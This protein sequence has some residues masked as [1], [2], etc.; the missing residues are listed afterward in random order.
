MAASIIGIPTT[1]V[2]DLFIRQRL[3]NQVQHDQADLFRLQMQL[4]TGRRFE[5]PSEAPVAALRVMSLQRLLERKAQVA[6]NLITNQS[7]LSNTDVTLSSV[8]NNMAEVR[9]T[10]LG[11][12]GTLATDEQRRAAA[13]Q[14]SQSLRSLLE[15]GNQ[16][17]RGR[18][19][20]AGTLTSARPFTSLPDGTVRYNGNE[21]HVYS[22]ADVN[23]LFATNLHGAE[24]FG[25]MSEPVRGNID[26]N[27]RLTLDTR[28][29][30]LRG[31]RG[32]SKGSIRISDGSNVSTID[33]S[34][35]ETIGDL[36]ALIKANP[37]SGRELFVEVTSD[38]I[39]IRLGG[40]E[41]NLSIH[42]VGGGTVAYE[43]GI[44][45]DIG[46]GLNPITGRDLDPVLRGTTSLDDVLGVRAWAVLHSPGADNDIRIVADQPGAK[47]ADGI[48]LNGLKVSLLNDP[49]IIAGNELVDYDPAAGTLVVRIQGGS[50]TAA[51]VAAAIN[52]RADIPYTASIDR[53]DDVEGGRGRVM[54]GISAVTAEGAGEAFDRRGLRIENQNETF[55]ADFFAART[56]EDLL[57]KLNGLGAGLLA[58]IN[59]SRT[60]I[61][62]R[63]RVSGCD[64]MIGENGGGTAE[65]LGLRTFNERTW[66]EDLNYGR[67]VH[68]ADG[69][70]FTI[71]IAD[72]SVLE[73]DVSGLA[74]IGDV[75]ERINDLAAAHVP[76]LSLEARLAEFGNGI[77]LV[78]TSSGPNTLT[79]ERTLLSSAAVDLGLVPPGQQ[80]S[81][82]PMVTG[83]PEATVASAGFKNNVVIRARTGGSEYNGVT[84]IFDDTIP[85]GD[86]A[87]DPD[88]K[89]L[90][91][92][93]Q[94]GRTAQ[95]LLDDLAGSPAADHFLGELD[96]ADGTGN[97]GTGDVAPTDPLDPPTAG[98]GSLTSHASALVA[99]AGFDNDLIFTARHLGGLYNGTQIHFVDVPGSGAAEVVAYTAGAELTIR[100]DST[101]SHTA[102][103]VMAAV[104]AHPAANDHWIV[105]RDPAD[106]S[107]NDG[108]EP[109]DA[110]AGVLLEGGMQT[111]DGRDTRP[112][113][114]ESLF[115][116]LLRLQQAL[117]VNDETGI[118]RALEMLDRKVVDLNFSRA[119]LGARQQGIEML[120]Y[121]ID[122][123]EV[124]LKNVLS[125]EY[126]ADLVEV[127]SNLSGRQAAF[128]AALR[129]MGMTMK[130]SLL[131]YL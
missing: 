126:D 29:D 93:I 79:V 47:T 88:A 18:Y 76:P 94:G 78:D 57:N 109:V 117:E 35:A 92:G 127:I 77:A 80:A 100:F 120:Q 129:S 54:A 23:L 62:L 122:V 87:Y 20:F 102:N 95:E 84:V 119:E 82:A 116:A 13:Q 17:F 113:E 85:P 43:L 81:T 51:N 104:A 7:Y 2:S 22:F 114:V 14:V 5:A 58:E 38:R 53:L 123:E 45:Q 6:S 75:I 31:G 112:L 131:N 128:E 105:G 103:D 52:A 19:L 39:R 91:F 37:P 28:I 106:E 55:D 21:G 86:P 115:T 34:S 15:T 67:G 3:L 30:D 26:L 124:E 101:A 61:N 107:P 12:I 8:S 108:S 71:T 10:A 64:F 83:T 50:S 65:Q 11:V 125:L 32:I 121:R 16:M 49:A 90:T 27:P 97:D 63:S 98:G 25:A 130:M 69:T 73:V 41:G 70:D 118:E 33:L 42:E 96:P 60:G 56:V 48:E 110:N 72:G 89:T 44:L 66:L 111:F 36:A 99:S 59:Q 46:V 1:R 24:V 74:N 4:S 40:T 9:G 68:T